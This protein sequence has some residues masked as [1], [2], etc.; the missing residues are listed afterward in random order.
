[1][2]FVVRKSTVFT[3]TVKEKKLYKIQIVITKQ[4]KK[5]ADSN[6]LTVSSNKIIEV[7]YSDTK[8]EYFLTQ[9]ILS[10]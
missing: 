2:Y 1:M 4:K 6:N 8:T 7:D 3:Q 9:S 10:S 5:I